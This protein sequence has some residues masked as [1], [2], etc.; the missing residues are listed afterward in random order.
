VDPGEE[1]D[2]CNT[3]SGDGCSAT[4]MSECGDGVVER[5]EECDDG[6]P[7]IDTDQLTFA[8]TP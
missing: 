1:C 3:V 7:T 6:K 4:C 2:D 8:C 5:G